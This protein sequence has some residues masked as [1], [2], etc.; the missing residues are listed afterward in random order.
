MRLSLATNFDDALLER[1]APYP[2][3]EVFGKLS[4]DAAGGGRSSLQLSHIGRRRVKEHVAA[5]RRLGIGFNYLLNASCLDNLEFTRS[6]QKALRKLLDWISSIGAESVTVA[7]PFL[8]RIVKA[9]YPALRVRVSVFAGVDHVRKARMWEDMGAD[10][11]M[12][13]SLLVNREF[14]LLR[15]IRR[16]VRCELQ[17]MLNNSCLQSCAMSPYHMNT[18][19]HASQSGHH[20]R[21][22]FIDW[23]F[24]RCTAMKLKDP[25]H[26]IRSEWIRPE[27][28]HHYEALGYDS[29]KVTERGVPT[30]VLVRRVEAYS[31]RTY[32]GN[33]LDLVQAFGFREVRGD[34]GGRGFFRRLRHLFRPFTVRLSRLW[35]VKRLAEERGLLGSAGDPPVVVDNRALDG[36]I[37]RFLHT[38]CKDVDCDSCR[39]CHR[40][41]E[42]AV[43]IDPAWKARCEALSDEVLADMETGRMW[44]LG[45]APAG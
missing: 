5:A 18:L 3:R 34:E 27:D 38:G 13:D 33:L 6:G 11:V 31:R 2:V 1:V 25:V 45:K 16:S 12:L 40:W 7:S 37:E 9:C 44:G 32:E 10:C 15:A 21:G 23:C 30:D 39:Y 43:R 24:L 42:K 20:T 41:A 4:S 8:L 19:A 35:R 28:L 14:E 36:F 17:L 22:F 29:F 26:Y